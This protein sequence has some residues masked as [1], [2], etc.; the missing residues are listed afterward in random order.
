[1]TSSQRIRTAGALLAVLCM[2]LLAPAARA[3]FYLERTINL[4]A[5]FGPLGN[6]P[7][8]VV[9][10]GTYAYVAGY[11]SVEPSGEAGILKV[12]LSDPADRMALDGGTQ[13]MNQ[14][15]AYIGLV[16]RDGVLYAMADRPQN[17]NAST[18]VR[19]INTTTG[20][21]VPEFDG[22]T[23]TGDGIA[24]DP[25]AI[26]T[27][28]G[29]MAYDPGV[30]GFDYGL[31]MLALGSGR[32]V[33]IGI[34]DGFTIYDKSD[35]MIVADVSGQCAVSDL[36][37]WR[38]HVYDAAGNVYM[39]RSNQVQ[40]AIRTGPNVTDGYA[41]RHLTDELN[42]DGTP[43]VGCGDGKPVALRLQP[44][45]L[46]QHIEHIPGTSTGASGQ[47]LLIFNDRPNNDGGKAFA[48]VIKMV[49]TNGLLPD[50]PVQLL[51][52]NGLPLT[53]VEV[54]N[55]AALYDFYYLA[56]VDKL[57]IL[58]FSARNLLVFSNTPPGV[59]CN[60]PQQDI[61]GNGF[62]DLGDYA[63]LAECMAGPNQPW[64]GPPVDQD[65]CRCLDAD[66]DDDIDLEDFA[67]FQEVFSG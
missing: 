18:N 2:G 62:V 24:W 28:T 52:S 36:T 40:M 45:S 39:R 7:I 38:D 57:L 26:G 53:T 48:D 19:A 11:T 9:S 66:R 64:P 27:A 13:E 5:D 60:D 33:L 43:K 32:R 1:M 42:A 44:F 6:N 54:P 46:G 29:G 67:V 51:N 59:L 49:D 23:G 8:Q 37:S 61:D 34:E 20:A 50:P 47:E 16:V 14:F 22:D 17:T 41:H 30:S 58:D 63:K 31:S 12:N 15:R 3:D 65:A 35:G 4:D 10:D 56:D 55:S 21:L 25:A